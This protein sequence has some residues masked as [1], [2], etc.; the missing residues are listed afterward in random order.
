MSTHAV[1]PHKP[2]EHVCHVGYDP[3]QDSFFFRVARPLVTDENTLKVVGEN[4]GHTI[5]WEG[6]TPR[7]I[8]T[9]EQLS[10]RL[11]PYATLPPGMYETLRGDRAREYRGESK[12]IAAAER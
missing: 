2:L 9:V 4:D 11:R 5:V 10:T 3:A 6:T 1:T 12:E 8:E 7:E